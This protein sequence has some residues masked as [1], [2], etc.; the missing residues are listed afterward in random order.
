MNCQSIYQV[1]DKFIVVDQE[2]S[3][4]E[5]NPYLII[6]SPETRHR[7]MLSSD[8]YFI[9]N[10][11]DYQLEDSFPVYTVL[12]YL[13]DDVKT[14]YNRHAFT[15]VADFKFLCNENGIYITQKSLQFYDFV[16]DI[17][18]TCNYQEL[19]DFYS[20][21]EYIV[22]K[23]LKEIFTKDVDIALQGL[24]EVTNLLATKFN[25]IDLT[26]PEFTSN[27]S[28]GGRYYITLAEDHSKPYEGEIWDKYNL[29]F[30]K[31]PFYFSRTEAEKVAGLLQI[32]S[33]LAFSITYK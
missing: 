25:E 26:L 21:G 15:Y 32:Y 3:V 28:R 33:G 9:I 4:I 17:D 7:T 1:K 24:R 18:F 16:F 6:E 23:R 12:N 5:T 8:S 11:L 10:D 22:A 29:N 20:Y 19:Y 30:L 14:A 2:D 13:T 27:A 31:Q